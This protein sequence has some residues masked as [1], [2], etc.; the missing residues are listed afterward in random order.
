MDLAAVATVT[1]TGIVSTFVNECDQLYAAAEATSKLAIT[2]TIND[3]ARFIRKINNYKAYKN[4]DNNF[5]MF[6][7]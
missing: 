2:Y 6:N 1:L 4:L 3:F 5:F 7:L